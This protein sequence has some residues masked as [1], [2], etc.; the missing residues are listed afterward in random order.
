MSNSFC[1]ETTRESELHA[2]VGHGWSR[3]QCS[4]FNAPIS[5]SLCC[6]NVSVSETSSFGIINLG[7]CVYTA[8]HNKAK[9]ELML[10]QFMI[11]IAW[12]MVSVAIS[13]MTRQQKHTELSKNST[14]WLMMFTQGIK[15][16]DIN[17]V[18]LGIMSVMVH[19]FSF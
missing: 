16:Y 5:G 3:V 9:T 10:F 18:S 4:E 13:G 17:N 14:H 12:Q 1:Q 15:L 7:R 2:G 19:L 8:V 6:L 11:C